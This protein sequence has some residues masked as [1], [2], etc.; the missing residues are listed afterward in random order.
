MDKVS[1]IINGVIESKYFAIS[2]RPSVDHSNFKL[3]TTC[4]SLLT[5]LAQADIMADEQR[6]NKLQ[7]KF[8]EALS[9]CKTEE[10]V[11][12]LATFLREAA[13]IG[14]YAV[15]FY[16]KNIGLINSDGKRFADQKIKE[17]ENERAKSVSSRTKE[18]TKSKY[19][20]VLYRPSEDKSNTKLNIICNSLITSMALADIERDEK[21]FSKLHEKFLEALSECKT[22]EEVQNFSKFMR[23][24]SKVGGYAVQF[25]NENAAMFNQN[26]VVDARKN[27]DSIKQ[28][29]LNQ[30]SSKNKDEIESSYFDIKYRPNGGF[31]KLDAMC[32]SLLYY[33]ALADITREEKQINDLT[34][35]FCETLLLCKSEEE[36]NKLSI[37]LNITANAGGY[38]IDFNKKYQGLINPNGKVQARHIIKISEKKNKADEEKLNEFKESVTSLNIE[39]EELKDSSI[40]DEEDISYLL[41]KFNELQS[42]LYSFSGSIDKVF[43][44]EYDERLEEA[45]NYLKTLYMNLDEINEVNNKF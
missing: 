43:I 25:Y 19:F 1:Q 2:Y 41:R 14:G 3:N 6:V 27:I 11:H 44:E 28:S 39:L 23:E 24:L 35:R 29:K 16:N 37:F 36:L 15:Q 40:K 9:K 10:E 30:V 21:R 18:G 5:C 31:T 12:N 32:S 22:K 42:D 26:S 38:A 8:L 20:D 34:I 45:I 17:T 33:M 4:N 13:N 7:T